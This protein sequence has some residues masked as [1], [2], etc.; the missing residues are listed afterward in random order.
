[1]TYEQYW[2]QDPWLAKWYREAYEIK[3]DEMNAKLWL[4]GMYNHTGVTIALGNAFRKKGQKAEKYLEKPIDLH[5]EEKSV[6][7]IRDETVD[8]L[9]RFERLWRNARK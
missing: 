1:M 3:R 7:A 6:K 9:K 5:A 8:K 4:Q 2:E